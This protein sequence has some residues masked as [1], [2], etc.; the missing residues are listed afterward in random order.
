MV[1]P[2]MTEEKLS[3]L[4]HISQPLSVIDIDTT[5]MD[6]IT[7]SLRVIRSLP[8]FEPQ[9]NLTLNVRLMR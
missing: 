8:D 6:A 4:T 9:F 7:C 3:M 2:S 1:F 5:A